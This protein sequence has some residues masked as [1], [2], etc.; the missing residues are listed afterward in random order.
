MFYVTLNKRN[1]VTF[2][3]T[4]TH[5][6]V[7]IIA[8]STVRH[9]RSFSKTLYTC[10]RSCGYS[11]PCSLLYK[12]SS[13]STL[14]QPFGFVST[15]SFYCRTW[16]GSLPLANNG[17]HFASMF[18]FVTHCIFHCLYTVILPSQILSYTRIPFF[19]KSELTAC[20]AKEL[21]TIATYTAK[22]PLA[23]ARW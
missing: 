13:S 20:M 16:I 7:R 12:P 10:T 5:T 1:P 19:F 23:A 2:R 22:L 18:L 21:F 15:P 4:Q 6:R 3:N 11:G 8:L 17:H 14:H 9:A